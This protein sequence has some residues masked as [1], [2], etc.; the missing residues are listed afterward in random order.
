MNPV[1]GILLKLLSVALFS[2]MVACVKAARET[3]PA[4]ETV[5]FRSFL[6]LI[7]VLVW[8]LMQGQLRR[9]VVTANLR[10]HFWRGLIGASAMICGFAA[11]GMLPLPEVT[12]IGFAA[13][14]I[15][16]IL[17]VFL[18]GETV[19]IYRWSAVGVGLLG[20]LIMIWPRLGALSD[21]LS[22]DEALGALLALAGAALMALAVIHVRWLTRT[23]HTLAIVFWFHVAC[24]A[25]AL[26]SL[27][28][29]WVWP[30]PTA[31]LL[32]IGAGLAGGVAQIFLTLSYRQADASTIAPFDY[33]MMIYALLI[34]WLIFGEVP[35]RQVL[36]GSAIVIAAGLFILLRERKLGLTKPAPLRRN[37]P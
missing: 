1:R 7:P 10:G 33:S 34:A 26:L 12:A 30:S 6:A 32:L 25:V 27:P 18:L 28:L 16:T 4:G 22:T 8:A 24:S 13:P 29:G 19:R 5:F 15:T 17:A 9:A 31:W 11:L 21:G 20:V 36:I 35:E 23:E 14:L 3:V 37:V 2:I